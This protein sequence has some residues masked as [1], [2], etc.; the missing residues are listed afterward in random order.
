MDYR[1]FNGHTCQYVQLYTC[2]QMLQQSLH[3]KL[4]LGEKS[5]AAPGHWTRVS[6]VS[7]WCSTD[8]ATSPLWTLKG[9]LKIADSFTTIMQLLERDSDLCTLCVV[10]VNNTVPFTKWNLMLS[11]VKGGV[12]LLLLFWGDQLPSSPS[13]FFVL[14]WV[15]EFISSSICWLNKTLWQQFDVP[16]PAERFKHW[17]AR[18]FQGRLFPSDCWI[19]NMLCALNRK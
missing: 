1:I 15:C 13:L 11:L 10:I 17:M 6:S 7:V 16:E 19:A 3:R 9:W 14:F 8:W 4:I 18:S 2:V 12:V 5:L